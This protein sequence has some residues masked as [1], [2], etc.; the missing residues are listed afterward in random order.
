MKARLIKLVIS[1]T[2][3][4]SAL[5]LASVVSGHAGDCTHTSVTIYEGLNLTGDSQ[6]FCG[7]HP[8]FNN[9]AHAPAGNCDN[10]FLGDNSWDD[11]ASSWR[12]NQ[13]DH[14]YCVQIFGNP[15]YNFPLLEGGFRP[16]GFWS[17]MDGGTGSGGEENKAT[18]IRWTDVSVCGTNP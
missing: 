5:G 15:S 9:V 12:V 17:N 7:S 18:S 1:L 14:G 6:T 4:L 2:L 13:N 10:H 11:C 16:A 8:D 3:V